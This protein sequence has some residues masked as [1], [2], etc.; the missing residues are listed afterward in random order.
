MAKKRF[1]A[2]WESVKQKFGV[3]DAE[4]LRQ[5]L[6]GE[7]NSSSERPD[8]KGMGSDSDNEIQT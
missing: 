5:T 2:L 6:K 3:S 1:N 4:G 7:G 8:E